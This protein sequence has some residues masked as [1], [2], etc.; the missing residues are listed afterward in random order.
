MLSA[1]VQ[2]LVMTDDL[3]H[4]ARVVAADAGAGGEQVFRLA[5]DAGEAALHA[6]RGQQFGR[7]IGGAQRQHARPLIGM[8][9]LHQ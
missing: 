5:C 7:R 9:N 6:Q 8:Q 1:S 3:P 2:E 4:Q